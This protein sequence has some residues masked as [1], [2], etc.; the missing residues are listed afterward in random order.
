[1][2]VCVD[3]DVWS[4]CLTL[5]VSHEAFSQM[6]RNASAY[7][8]SVKVVSHSVD[9]LTQSYSHLSLYKVLVWDGEYAQIVFV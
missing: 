5:T 4:W 1:M 3:V 6:S 9:L 2:C 7:S 8:L